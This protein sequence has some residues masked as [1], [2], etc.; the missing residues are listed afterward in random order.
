ML[1]S[2]SFGLPESSLTSTRE[3]IDEI[4]TF[5][6]GSSVDIMDLFRIGKKIDDR[7]RPTIVKLCT[8]WDKRL[9]LSAKK[10]LKSFRV[11]NI[12]IRQ[13]LSKEERL[14]ENGKRLSFRSKQ[15][16]SVEQE[17]VS[18]SQPSNIS[19]PFLNSSLHSPQVS[20]DSKDVSGSNHLD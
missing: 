3:L 9:L 10:K 20:Q 13:N 16:T 15:R 4:S 12:F 2:S 11:R 7:C 19:P 18:H 5:L 6:L 14:V 8:V 17:C 1:M